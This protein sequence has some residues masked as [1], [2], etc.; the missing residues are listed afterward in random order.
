MQKRFVCWLVGIAVCI[1]ILNAVPV[2]AASPPEEGAALPEIDLSVPKDAD[3]QTY[4]GLSGEGL[5]QI[6]Q[7]EAKVVIIEIF[8]M[9]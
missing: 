6:R 4:L 8:N 7:I 5:F 2:W 3:H 1:M 9:Y